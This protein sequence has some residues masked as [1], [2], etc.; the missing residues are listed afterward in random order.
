MSRTPT[1][2]RRW[3]D[4]GTDL[5]LAAVARLGHDDLDAPTLLVDWNRRQLLAHVA[6]NAEAVGNLVD[7][8]ATGVENP[9][10][11][12]PQSRAEGIE[13]GARREAGDL[14]AWVASS[15]ATLAT[16]MD[17]LDG[18]QWQHEVVTAQGSTVPATEVPWM[19]S[20]EVAVHAVDLAVG[21]TF[22]DL[23]AD[24]LA[25]LCDDVVGKRNGA[26]AVAVRLVATDTEGAWELRGP[27]APVTVEAP[28]AD[29]T[30]YLTGRPV[31]LTTA[32]GGAAPALPAWL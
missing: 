13:Q 32:D 1:D 26:P 22:D 10:Y 29:L 14:L 31:A 15:A 18:A 16:A 27:G 28:L 2:A 7:W 17:A 11:A 9:M 8:A 6:A 19:R 30:A 5:L 20:R 25:A 12:S 3:M 24:F 4:Q 21:T 23:P